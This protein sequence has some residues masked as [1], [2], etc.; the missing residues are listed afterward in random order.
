LA[1]RAR[2]HVI[3]T[4]H[5]KSAALPHAHAYILVL[6]SRISRSTTRHSSCSSTRRP[7]TIP[8]ALAGI[9][10]ELLGQG[11]AAFGIRRG[12]REPVGHVLQPAPSIQ[13]SVFLPSSSVYIA[14][15]DA[16]AHVVA[17]EHG[18]DSHAPRPPPYLLRVRD[19]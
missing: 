18:S 7:S 16:D 12:R 13:H 8:R 14:L 19:E 3:T 17:L 15:A 9:V 2:G 10:Q 6:E 4:L 5:T 11:R 1:A